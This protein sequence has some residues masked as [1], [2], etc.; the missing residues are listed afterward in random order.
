MRILNDQIP[1]KDAGRQF[2]AAPV[3]LLCFFLYLAASC[4]IL[5][6]TRFRAEKPHAEMMRLASE[7][8]AR[9]FAVLKEE[10]LRRGYG[11]RVPPLR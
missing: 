10:R 7:Q 1:Q 8:T 2:G 4:F 9:C 6:A 5:D 3:L 11:R